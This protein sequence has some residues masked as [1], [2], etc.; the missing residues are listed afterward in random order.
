MTLQSGRFLTVIQ[1]FEITFGKRGTVCDE[2]API[3]YRPYFYGR[4]CRWRDQSGWK[5]GI[6]SKCQAFNRATAGQRLP[7]LRQD[8]ESDCSDQP[9]IVRFFCVGCTAVG[10]KSL[11]IR[12]GAMAGPF[13]D[14]HASAA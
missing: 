1:F 3:H 4:D 14:A 10:I 7:Q 8:L 11:C 13:G 5:I 12:K 6:V 2:A 9:A